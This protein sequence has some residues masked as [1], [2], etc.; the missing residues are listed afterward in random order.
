MGSPSK[1]NVTVAVYQSHSAVEAAIRELRKSG[2]DWRKISVAGRD[3]RDRATSPNHL[4]AFW[5]AIWGM[6]SDWDMF[7][8]SD[9]G[10]VFVAGPLAEWSAAG[11][12]NASLFGGL[13]ALG[14]GLYSIG[15][16]K[17]RILQYESALKEDKYLVVVHG[18]ADEVNHAREILEGIDGLRGL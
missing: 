1:E 6:L 16:P 7:A 2:F 10:L 9:I 18:S 14:A 15:I 3:Y 17:S 12:E 5:T 13:S 4:G 8:I 11:M